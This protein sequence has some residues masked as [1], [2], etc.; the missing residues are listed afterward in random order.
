MENVRLRRLKA[1]HEALR[2]LAHLHPKIE[3]EGVVGNPPERY[4]VLLKVR[5]LRERG[6]EIVLAHEHRLEVTLPKGY[7]RDAPVFRML[8]PVFHPNIAPHA[9][10]I[11]DHWTASEAL[12]ALIQRVGEMLAYQS[13]NIKSP[14]NGRAAQWVDEHRD[15]VP[16]DRDEFFLDLSHAPA[17]VADAS[18]P[19]CG[20][21]GARGVAL[22][23]C[24]ANHGS[25]QDCTPHCPTCGRA[26]CLQCGENAKTCTACLAANPACANCGTRGVPLTSCGAGH[27]TCEDCTPRC[28]SCWRPLCLVCGVRICPACNARGATI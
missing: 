4:R 17:Q 11:G 25:C 13:Y 26:L 2:R 7:P 3:I 14:L 5:S 10:C 24:Q 27:A 22:N 18:V 23:R 20:N 6:D 21:C 28:E 19:A 12:D 1:D 9:V 15:Q 8:T 16:T